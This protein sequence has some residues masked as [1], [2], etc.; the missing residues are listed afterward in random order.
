MAD[1]RDVVQCQK[2]QQFHHRD[3]DRCDG[4]RTPEKD[5]RGIKVLAVAPTGEHIVSMVE[6]KGRVFVATQRAIYEL[7]DGRLA[8]M[9][10]VG[11]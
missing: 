8:Q 4:L 3:S 2:C 7:L 6:R 1:P 5:W 11:G 9:A 10:V